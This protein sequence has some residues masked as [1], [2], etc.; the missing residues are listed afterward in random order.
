MENPTTIALS[1]LVAQQRALDVTATNLA[2][3]NTPAFRAERTLF[4]D[5][6]AREPSLGTPPGGRSISYTQDRA[7]YREQRA[8][9]VRHTGN[10]LDLAIASQAGWFTVQAQ[11][12]PRL[13]RAGH[14]QLN[15]SGA[16][17]DEQ[18]DAL[19]DVNGRPL[20]TTPSDTQLSVAGDGTL[21]SENGQI[22]RIGVMQPDDENKMQAEGARLFATTSATTAVAAPQIVQGAV[23]DS[24]VQPITELNRMMTD[25][26]EFQFTSQ[27]IQGE[28]DRQNAAIEKILRRGA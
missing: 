2:N 17:V 15:A 24:N 26:R 18:G 14:F 20:Q 9:T 21:S 7:T 12:G 23:E 4:S 25:L 19:L 5:W 11:A 10:P 28:S 22:G 27:I 3:A 8:G 13:T 1:R 16:V 6:L